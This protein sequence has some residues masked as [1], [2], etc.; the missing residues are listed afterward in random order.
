MKKQVNLQLSNKA[1][2][3]LIRL[4]KQLGISCDEFAT[5]CFEYIDVKHQG[6]ITAAEKIRQK[7]SKAAINK[8]NLSQHLKQLSAEQV[9]LL[10]SKAAQQKK[11]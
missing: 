4:S 2:E 1:S 5:L 11:N 10:L 9:A 3:Q 7:K 6:I 8:K